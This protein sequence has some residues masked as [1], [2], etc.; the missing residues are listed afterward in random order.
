MRP[1]F[2]DKTAMGAGF[3]HN[4]VLVVQRD[5]ISRWIPNAGRRLR[6]L[7]LGCGA[8]TTSM[9]LFRDQVL[10]EVRSL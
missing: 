2:Y 9:E 7:D 5:Q 8:G 4:P 6:V 3:S 10:P 1:G